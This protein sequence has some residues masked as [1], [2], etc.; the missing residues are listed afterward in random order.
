MCHETGIVKK[1][2]PRGYFEL[3]LLTSLYLFLVVISFRNYFFFLPN[4]SR[5]EKPI[6][7]TQVMTT[8]GW[9]ALIS[10][11][12]L[13]L[14]NSQRW[15]KFYSFTFLATA[16]IWPLST[17]TI[18][19]LNLIYFGTPYVGYLS[20]HPLFLLMEFAVP[21]FYIYLWVKIRRQKLGK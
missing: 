9:V 15:G 16:L 10:I 1:F 19:L 21:A 14:R 12:P 17:L 13:L 2:N 5:S 3:S 18:K 11:P 6:A 4:F 8:I 20:A 7:F